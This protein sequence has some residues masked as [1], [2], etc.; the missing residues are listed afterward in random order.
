MKKDTLTKQLTLEEQLREMQ[1]RLLEVEQQSMVYEERIAGIEQEKTIDAIATAKAEIE[2]ITAEVTDLSE[3]EQSD[4]KSEPVN[5]I[6][7]RYAEVFE[8]HEQGKSI[9]VIGKLVGLQRGEIQLILQ[10][11][12]QE[13][14]S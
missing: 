11:A 10:L 14:A 7:H 8:L 3:L 1:Q 4:I 12:K 2:S 6:K 5:S 9:D 13:G